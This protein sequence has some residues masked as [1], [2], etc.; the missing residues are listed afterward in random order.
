MGIHLDHHSYDCVPTIPHA[1][2]EEFRKSLILVFT[3]TFSMISYHKPFYVKIQ[4]SKTKAC[5]FIYRNSNDHE[6]GFGKHT[7]FT[8]NLQQQRR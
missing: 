5:P 2:M 6:T 8:I 4:P 7:Y 3:V 1:Q